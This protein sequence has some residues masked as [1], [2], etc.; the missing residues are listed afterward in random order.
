MALKFKTRGSSED[1]LAQLLQLSQFSQQR[2]DR[3][4]R[5]FALMQKELGEGIEGIYDNDILNAKRQ[6]FD[7]YYSDNKDDMD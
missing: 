1:A 2:K 3:K 5:N 7:R 6:H 4:Q